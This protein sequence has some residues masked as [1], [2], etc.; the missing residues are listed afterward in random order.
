MEEKCTTRQVWVAVF[1]ALLAPASALPGVLAQGGALGWLVGPALTFPLALFVVWRL[2]RL[3]PGGLVA[4]WRR[5]PKWLGRA[6]LT[7]YYIW[8]MALS[9][10]TA[11]SCIDRLGRTDY[12]GAPGWLLAL[13]VTAVAAY[14]IYKGRGAFFRAAEIFY[15][16]LLVVLALFFILG[17][18]D[19]KGENLTPRGWSELKG[20]A[21]GTLSV[22]GSLSVGVLAACFPR[23]KPK[24]GASPGWRWLAG[25]CA[26][27]A[28]LALLV[29]G[30]LGPKLAA[31][32]PLPFFLTLQGLGFSGGFQRL[33]ALGTAAWVL[34]DLALLGLAAL[35]GQEMAGGRR[36]GAIPPLVCALIGGCFLSNDMVR[37]AQ[38]VLL[39][40]NLAL[41]GAL[42]VLLSLWPEKRAGGISCG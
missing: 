24:Q 17:A 18:A 35:A 28:G 2:K 30:M 11:G 41:G 34:S 13:A 5:T 38:T 19:L 3:G 37:G 29:I 26:T 12:L 4:A 21:A 33:E 9:A 25:W 10:L 22:S 39:G 1:V 31:Q 32:A 15:L 36:W 20:A 14:L 16:A 40:V 8:A 23:E 27:V 7:L 42:P 6:A